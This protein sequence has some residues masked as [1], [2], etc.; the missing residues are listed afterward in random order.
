M[1]TAKNTVISHD[2]LVW[3]LCVKEQFQVR[4]A[5][6]FA[7]TVFT[8]NFHTRK[9]GEITVIFRSSAKSINLDN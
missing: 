3:K 4:F 9:F 2:F 5:R 1:T 7:E 8:Q 6:Y